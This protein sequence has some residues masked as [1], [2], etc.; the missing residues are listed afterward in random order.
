MRREGRAVLIIIASRFG[1][2]MVQAPTFT[3]L[4]TAE[5]CARVNESLCGKKAV[6]LWATTQPRQNVDVL[7]ALESALRQKGIAVLFLL[8]ENAV[9]L[10]AAL[11]GESRNFYVLDDRKLLRFLPCIDLLV[12][13]D[14]VADYYRIDGFHGK[15]L[16]LNHVATGNQNIARNYYNDYIVEINAKFSCAFDY[17]LVPSFLSVQ[18]N[19]QLAVIP[20]GSIKLDLLAEARARVRKARAATGIVSFYPLSSEHMIGDNAEKIARTVREWSAFVEGFFREHPDGTFV[21][22]PSMADRGR[23]FILNFAE[24]W[25]HE[26]R[27]IFSTRDDNKYWISRSDFLLTDWSG[28]DGSWIFSSL[29]PALYLRPDSRERPGENAYGYVTTTGAEALR[30]LARAQK[31]LWRWK[32]RLLK[33]RSEQFPF[34]GKSLARHCEAIRH[35]I[36]ADFPQALPAWKVLDKNVLAENPVLAT[37][38]CH[39]LRK[40]NPEAMRQLTPEN[41]WYNVFRAIPPNGSLTL[42]AIDE[43]IAYHATIAPN[44]LAFSALLSFMKQAFSRVPQH[45]VYTF[46]FHKLAAL[47]RSMYLLAALCITASH[48][49]S[50]VEQRERTA[51]ALRAAALDMETISGIFSAHVFHETDCISAKYLAQLKEAC[52]RGPRRTRQAPTR[53]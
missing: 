13:H 17:S 4:A 3:P 16:Y 5:D 30:A 22:S 6:A 40:K 19:P 37:L 50:T 15:V 31:E 14:Y 53:G 38:R 46:L 47:P 42:A 44:E 48:K 45:I 24:S 23:E 43:L 11:G 2:K 20:A 8:K 7:L 12:T 41:F 39:C 49:E 1:E 21:F 18:H 25:R 9:A 33:F 36:S 32:A 28:I 27:F 35:I 34:F 51:T 29:R 10:V 26:P 52:L